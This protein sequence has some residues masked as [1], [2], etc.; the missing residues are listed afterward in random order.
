MFVYGRNSCAISFHYRSGAKSMICKFNRLSVGQSFLSAKTNE[1]NS[2]RAM[3]SWHKQIDMN[4]KKK[5]IET[6]TMTRNERQ[7]RKINEKRMLRKRDFF[8]RILNWLQNNFYTHW[9]HLCKHYK[10]LQSAVY[11]DADAF[12]RSLFLFVL[13]L[14][15]AH[16]HIHTL[17]QQ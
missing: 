2:I 8:T 4:Q 15:R 9:K 14:S 5:R 1:S 11:C 6:A 16:A 7:K 17:F 10:I 3:I 12:I 13:S